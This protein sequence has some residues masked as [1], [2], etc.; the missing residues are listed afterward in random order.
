[1]FSQLLLDGHPLRSTEDSFFNQ[2]SSALK[3]NVIITR[4][5]KGEIISEDYKF[6][7]PL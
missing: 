2:A 6:L 4:R 3:S 1:M 7:K 5:N